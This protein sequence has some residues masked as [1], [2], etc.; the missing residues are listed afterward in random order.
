MKVGGLTAEEVLDGMTKEE[1]SLLL[2]FETAAVDHGGP[3]ATKH[4]NADDRAIATRWHKQGFIEFGRIAA[5]SLAIFHSS[6][7]THYVVLSPWALALAQ[8]ERRARIV[9]LAARRAWR[10]ASEAQ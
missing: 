1:R 5:S 7:R 4:M 9:R 2:F 10:K 3:L 8:A 6:D